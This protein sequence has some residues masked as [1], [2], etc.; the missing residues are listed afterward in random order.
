M[1]EMSVTSNWTLHESESLTPELAQRIS[2]FRQGFTQDDSRDIRSTDA[3]YYLWKFR[4]NPI[5][6]GHLAIAYSSD[7]QII[8]LATCTWRRFQYRGQWY[9]AAKLGDALTDANFRGQGI[10][11]KLGNSC[12]TNAQKKG[13]DIVYFNPNEF[14]L[15]VAIKLDLHQHAH[16]NYY[17]WLLPL[18]V[19]N[20]IRTSQFRFLQTAAD[21][22]L[23]GIT[24][25]MSH[26]TSGTTV[27]KPDF[28]ENFDRLNAQLGSKFVFHYD[29][30]SSYL[31]YRYNQ[32][33]DADQYRMVTFR[34]SELHAVLIFKH[35]IQ[36]GLR[37]LSVVDWYGINKSAMRRVW[38]RFLQTAC[39][40]NY[41]MVA[42]WV[43]RK[44]P[45]IAAMMPV[46]P[47]PYKRKSW[48]ISAN[49][50][51]KKLL[52]EK[53]GLLFTATEADFI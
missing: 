53:S 38:L 50:T 13:T 42:T 16:I 8:G 11:T 9:T 21:K 48:N 52:A 6:P 20:L 47:L 44:M 49:E 18:N 33:P 43:P 41:D 40:E 25:I 2:E 23:R 39:D 3:V 35:T 1:P 12:I 31:N 19:S 28:D 17:S 29:K 14:S 45:F 36:W 27:T 30:S 15:S 37:V 5:K 10:N 51:G 24:R 7:E 22:I 46:I 4:D 34:N 26:P 32:N